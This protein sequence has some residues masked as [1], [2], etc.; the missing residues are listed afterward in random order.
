[1][2]FNEDVMK[3]L[4]V[5]EII[6][7]IK[8]ATGSDTA[9]Q[10]S[11][12]LDE[13]D[14]L[15]A[16]DEVKDKK[17]ETDE[18]DIDDYINKITKGASFEAEDEIVAAE[19]SA[20]N[21]DDN[22]GFSLLPF[23]V[24]DEVTADDEIVADETIDDVL[25]EYDD[26]EDKIVEEAAKEAPIE[27]KEEAKSE[28]D[29]EIREI[30]DEHIKQDSETVTISDKAETS[31][32]IGLKEFAKAQGIIEKPAEQDAGQDT[33][34]DETE[35]DV[36]ISPLL[37]STVSAADDEETEPEETEKTKIIDVPGQISIEKTRLFNEVETR[38]VRND[39]IEHHIGTGKIIRT[40]EIPKKSSM[41]SDPYRERFLNKPEL[42]IEKTQEHKDW[43]AQ[44]PPKTI[45]KHG[46]VVKKPM[47]DKTG[48]DGLSPVPILV[49]AADEYDAQKK[50]ELENQQGGAKNADGSSEEQLDNQIVLE[51]FSEEEEIERVSE[52]EVEKKLRKARMKRIGDFMLFPNLQDDSQDNIQEQAAG[53]DGEEPQDDYETVDGDEKEAND[54]QENEEKPAETVRVARELFGPKD[55]RAVYDIYRSDNNALKL[56]VIISAV[57]LGILAI[58]SFATSVMNSFSLFADNPYVYSAINMLVLALVG[59]VNYK[60]FVTAAEQLKKKKVTS[61]GAIALAIT[62]GILQCIFSFAAGDLVLSG[63]HIYASVAVFPIL[64]I[65]IGEYIKS[66]NDVEN[67]LLLSKKEND[68]YALRKID[69]EN[70]AGEIGRGLMI[71]DPDIRYSS[72]VNFPYKFVE[73]SKSVDPTAEVFKLVIPV[74]LAASLIV[75][76]ICAVLN[77]SFFVGFT[78][79]T[80]VLLMAIPAAAVV[81][82]YGILR[83]T[84]KLLNSE[85]GM[86][87]GYEA[88]ENALESN[89]VAVDSSDMF[90]S[91]KAEIY[92]IKLFNSMRIDEAILYT[93]AVVIQSDGAL[94]DV[95]DSIILSKRE[96]LPPVESLAYE[97]KLGCSGWIYNYRVLVG[98]RDL[99]I[100]H[101][102]SVWSKQEENNFTAGGKRVVYLAV[103]GKVAA[104]FVVSYKADEVTAQYM[105]KLE[106][107]GISILVRTTDANITEEM[108]EQYFDLPHNF[109]KVISPVAGL[110]LQDISKET[111]LNE[112]C[113]IV[114]DGK[115]NS[116]LR[117]FSAAVTLSEQRKIGTVLQYIGTGI[118][119]LLMAMLSFLSGLSQAGALQII[120]F[121]V[122]WSL[123]VVFVPRIKKI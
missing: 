39:D 116:M 53:E 104:M 68:F 17:I 58:C 119:I 37:D 3:D 117:S 115:L 57:A 100:K 25:S 69:D 90:E 65:N 19:E 109:I 45:E 50:L 16:D 72:K 62:V 5:D 86:I 84:N 14:A 18:A 92:G 114:T 113:R 12:S 52:S 121:E 15:L 30:I 24:E 32:S 34:T 118:G 120:M 63:T 6:D 59:A 87:S 22:D 7:E 51:G 43:V 35:N 98:N 64:L 67:F 97:E 89:A 75:G 103:E 33:L 83:R 94:K 54:E 44:M 56:K 78:A 101:N 91:G 99:L 80:G 81:S 40:G 13:I 21:T 49:D 95:F 9:V 42:N 79:L 47:F 108:V 26:N 8:K 106:K 74:A 71:K 4:S 77:K 1:M 102:V 61:S 29:K 122:L 23:D 82:D 10:K 60:S 20:E 73:M 96:M 55:A 2:D 85:S 66:K 11:W 107:S 38:A 70:T 41:E 123:L 46:V 36:E 31:G 93:A 48:E 76:I 105:Q 111:A 88:V 27:I 112:P 28:L 110:M